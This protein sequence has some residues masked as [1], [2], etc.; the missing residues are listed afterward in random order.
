[1]DKS[2]AI[3]DQDI[4]I[5]KVMHH[6]CMHVTFLFTFNHG[7]LYED[8]VYAVKIYVLVLFWC[9]FPKDSMKRRKKKIISFLYE[10]S[11]LGNPIKHMI[12][13]IYHYY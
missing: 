3:I 9:F 1:M 7:F 4:Y 5:F 2:A 6:R 10:L 13:T 11:F 8:L 12:H